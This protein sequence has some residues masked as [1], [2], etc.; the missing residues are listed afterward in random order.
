MPISREKFQR[1]L[2]LF[3]AHDYDAA[4]KAVATALRVAP[5]DPNLLHLAARIAETRGEKE[6]ALV[7]YRRALD[8]NPG[9]P[10]AQ[11]NLASLLF[12]MEKRDDAISLMHEFCATRPDFPPAW[13]AFARF[14]QSAGDLPLAL[15]YWEK[16]LSL[17]PNNH[18]ARAQRILLKRHI[19]AW[20]D[21]PQAIDGL[22]PQAVMVLADDPELQRKAA[23]AYAQKR[24]KGL[25][26]F[27]KP[28]WRDH[29]RLRVGYVSSDFHAHATS[30]L[31]AELFEIHDRK[32]FE[33]F[34]YSYGVDDGSAMRRRLIDSAER[35]TD[36]RD[37]TAHQAAERI[38]H[39]EIDVL[40]D[41]KGHTRGSRL[42]ILAYKPA[43]VQ[44]HW[45]GYPGTLGTDFIDFFVGDPLTIPEDHA[46]HF[47]ERV[48]RTQGCYQINDRQRPVATTQPRAAYGLPEDGVILAS[49]NQT[50]KITPE[51]FALWCGILREA[52][53]TLLWLYESNPHAAQNLRMA[54]SSLG[55]DGA[56]LVFAP[57]L[58]LD[59][60]LARYAHVDL[61]LDTYPVGGHTTTSDALWTATPVI[62]LTGESFVARVAASL[63]H[64]AGLADLVCANEEAY[65]AK[66][67][68]LIGD[69]GT[70]QALRASLVEKRLSL[71][72]FD[73]PAFLVGWEKLLEEMA[74]SGR[75]I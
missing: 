41:L 17:A 63:L 12:A 30:Y 74:A 68:A 10:E 50:Y 6:R 36:I 66:I 38:R 13:E 56:R 14:H 16:T 5:K 27:P 20:D 23:I 19:C 15:K 4:A 32:R 25:K 33:V 47:T 51:M 22:P 52:P 24:F 53:N 21:A 1:I 40:I 43:R 71:P 34:A 54:A 39:D 42:D 11:F 65:R 35:F 60:H 26:P 46:R 2:S 31:M 45:L 3:H 75:I 7:L 44:V 59:R 73:T 67:L 64:A 57:A 58:P 55:V 70:R 29:E 18:E 48:A 8:A 28:T 69:H 37:L 9:W 49:F 72:L 62:T 61:A